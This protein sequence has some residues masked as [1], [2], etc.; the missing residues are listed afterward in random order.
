[1]VS[2][3]AVLTAMPPLVEHKCDLCSI[4]KFFPKA[5]PYP[6]IIQDGCNEDIAKEAEGDK[7]TGTDAANA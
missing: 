2:T 1:M 3:G 7:T 6:E 4:K 5:Y